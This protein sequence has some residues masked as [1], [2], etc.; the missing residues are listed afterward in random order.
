[1]DKCPYHS[2]ILLYKS[3]GNVGASLVVPFHLGSD[4]LTSRGGG[5]FFGQAGIFFLHVFRDRNFLFST[6]EGWNFFFFQCMRREVIFFIVP[7][8]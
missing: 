7:F 3:K 8:V 4:H 2:I 5:G 6:I 1:M